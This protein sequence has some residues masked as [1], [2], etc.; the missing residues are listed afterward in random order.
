MNKVIYA[1]GMVIILVISVWALYLADAGPKK[2]GVTLQEVT[3]KMGSEIQTLNNKSTPYVYV[4]NAVGYVLEFEN[5]AK[6][7][8]AGDTALTYDMKFVVGDYYKADVAFRPIG[9]VYT[10]GTDSAAF[11]ASVIN[12]GGLKYVVPIHYGKTSCPM[13]DADVNTFL[14]ALDKYQVAAEPAVFEPGDEKEIMGVKVL[15][16]GGSS[17]FFTSPD[18]TRIFID[19]SMQFNAALLPKYK[20]IT[21]FGG[22]DM[23]LLTHGHFDHMSVKDLQQWSKTYD[24]IIVAPYELGVF[25][26]GYVESPVL[27]INAGGTISSVEWA[28]TSFDPKRYAKMLNKKIHLIHAFHSSVATPAET[29]SFAA[30]QYIL[31]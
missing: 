14:G 19:P 26:S 29:S 6:F 31:K 11:A 27:S 15:F 22:V 12:P 2:L 18:G 24:P 17:W 7:Y 25:L 13:V 5:G 23:I 1:I 30:D 20:D 28:K 9:D 10:M 21:Q 16:L 3:Q 4:G 8:F